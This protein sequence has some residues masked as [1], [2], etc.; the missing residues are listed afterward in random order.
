MEDAEMTFEQDME[1]TAILTTRFIRPYC[2]D[3]NIPIS[4]VE[5]EMT[6]AQY[7]KEVTN[8]TIQ[9]IRPYCKKNNIPISDVEPYYLIA[10]IYM[11]KMGICNRNEAKRLF[12]VCIKEHI[13]PFVYRVKNGVPNHT[14]VM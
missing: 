7:V 11:V 14:K 13:D 10:I 8:W 2:Q 3:N 6:Y 9:F 12:D 1:L 4:D 5:F